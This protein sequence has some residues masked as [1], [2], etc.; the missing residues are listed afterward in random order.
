MY[1]P[2]LMDVEVV[3]SR[4]RRKTVSAQMVD[5]RL[6]VS[7]PAWMS[8]AEEARHVDDMVRRMTR[9]REAASIDIVER[10]R[11]LA[12]RY[13]LPEPATVRFVDNQLT[14]WGSCTP[15]DR[16]IRLSSRLAA[17]PSWVLDYVIV[18]ELAHLVEFRHN[19]RFHALV[20]R[21]PKTE[22]AIGF[23]IAKGLD[24]SDD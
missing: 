18:H 6:R 23:L 4:K 10:T 24:P 17:F 16:S 15:V 8:K 1:V 22:R 2:K 14:R 21:Y 13:D 9:R 5:G 11:M 3:R 20:G 12:R 19:A 7:I